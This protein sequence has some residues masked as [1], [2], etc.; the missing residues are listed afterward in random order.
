M[1][2]IVD[3]KNRFETSVTYS[4]IMMKTRNDAEGCH[5][6]EFL[7]PIA[8]SFWHAKWFY[9]LKKSL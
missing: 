1:I 2:L 5:M 3:Q 4:E 7:E 9:Y 8:N 6:T